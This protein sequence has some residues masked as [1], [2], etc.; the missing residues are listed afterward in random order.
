MFHSQIQTN[1]HLLITKY[2]SNL[3]MM[4]TSDGINLVFMQGW[5]FVLGVPGCVMQNCSA[6]EAAVTL[7][8]LFAPAS[9]LCILAELVGSESLADG[10][11]TFQGWIFLDSTAGCSIYVIS[12]F[13]M[14]CHGKQN[15]P[16][17]ELY[18]NTCAKSFALPG[19]PWLKIPNLK[20]CRRIFFLLI[21]M[22]SRRCGANLS[23]WNF[24]HLSELHIISRD[25]LNCILPG[26]IA[27]IIFL[28]WMSVGFLLYFNFSHLS[29]CLSNCLN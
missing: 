26:W 27:E 5:R 9:T 2:D 15:K 19:V 1:T 6:W 21:C 7:L 20:Y 10:V 3:Q 24:I 16:N 22:W 25:Y 12:I 8:G 11:L 14:F 4:L 29:E 18:N 23:L 13:I 28:T 17:L